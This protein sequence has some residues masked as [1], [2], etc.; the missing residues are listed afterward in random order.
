MAAQFTT[1]EAIA[2]AGI[3]F[4]FLNH[5]QEIGQKD[6]QATVLALIADIAA[7]EAS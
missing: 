5:N 2:I 7:I 3:V 4:D 6:A 1:D